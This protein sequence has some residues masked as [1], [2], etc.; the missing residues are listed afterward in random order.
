MIKAIFVLDYMDDESLRHYVHRALNRG[1]AYHQLQRTIEAVNG[2]KFRGS[3]DNEINIWNECARLISNSIIYFNSVILS[4]LLGH[5]ER[6]NNQE[7][8]ALVKTLSP[9]AWTNVNLNGTYSF[10]TNMGGLDIDDLLSI[11]IEN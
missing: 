2:G 4:K 6:H 1:E 7:M 9:V 10:A 11:L 5:F 8:V 3:S